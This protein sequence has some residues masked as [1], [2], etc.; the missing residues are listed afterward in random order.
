MHS[1]VVSVTLKLLNVQVDFYSVFCSLSSYFN[2]K[3]IYCIHSSMNVNNNR[4]KY[5]GELKEINI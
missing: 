5:A 3:F 4:K 1:D 2:I